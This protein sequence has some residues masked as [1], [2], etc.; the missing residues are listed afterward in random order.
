MGSG[1]GVRLLSLS[2]GSNGNCYYFEGS[3]GAFL[4]DAGVSLKALKAALQTYGIPFEKIGAVLVTHDHSDHIRN[5]GSYC[6]KL[7]I[8]VWV[9]SRIRH[10][11]P[12]GWMTGLW[13]DPVARILPSEGPARI[14]PGITARPFD[15]PHDATHTV[16]YT[17]EIDG[18][19]IVIM[20]DVGAMT[21]EA[22]AY[23]KEASTV[24]VEANYDVD[25]LAAGPYP[26]EL[27]ARIRGG[28]GHLSNDECA[29]AVRG[30]LHE[31]L[32][33]VFLCHLSAHNNTPEKALEAVG[34][35]LGESGVRLVALPR[36]EP[37]AMF[38]L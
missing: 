28:H 35:A 20:T 33:N 37:S 38:E 3:G 32:R 7:R 6:K 26:P 9:H 34:G 11:T 5:L 22:L 10:S 16:G 1:K 36:T 29:A 8:P 30:F 4:V 31:G 27:Q 24:I 21:P 14:L 18:T 25:M 2:S 15:I 23:A 12:M 19:R 17:L 13:L